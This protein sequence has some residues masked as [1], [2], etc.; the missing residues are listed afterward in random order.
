MHGHASRLQ[1]ETKEF[2]I[3][4]NR[5]WVLHCFNC[6]LLVHKVT[7]K[8]PDHCVV[9]K[10][11]QA[12]NVVP[13]T[14]MTWPF[15]PFSLL[16]RLSCSDQWSPS[17]KSLQGKHAT[18]HIVTVVMTGV[19]WERKKRTLDLALERKESTSVQPSRPVQKINLIEALL[20]AQVPSKCP[21]EVHSFS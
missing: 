14:F 19:S 6:R 18:E 17:S 20:P 13:F 1:P 3:R 5:S 10:F 21:Q 2:H 9:T 4:Y 15:S 7:A 16:L 8:R 12:K 11:Y